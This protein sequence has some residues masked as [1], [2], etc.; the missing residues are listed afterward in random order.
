MAHAPLSPLVEPARAVASVVAVDATVAAGLSRGLREQLRA[1]RELTKPR[2]T[3]LVTIT[4]GVGF[5]MGAIGRPEWFTLDLVMSAVG[6]LVGT[7]SSASGANA[8][9]QWMERDRDSLMPRTCAR[10]LPRQSLT[11]RVALSAGIALCVFGVATLLLFAGLAAALVSLSTIILYLLVY[12]PLKPVTTVSTIVGA[13]PGAL[14]PLIGWCAAAGVGVTPWYAPLQHAGGWSL[15]LLMFVWQIPHFLAIA[16]M[17]RE[18]YAKGGY[19]MLSL[20]DASGERTSS[21][22][23]LWS[24][25]LIPATLSPSLAIHDRLSLAY[26]IAATLT[27]LMYLWLGWKFYADR[28]RGNARRVFFASI[29]HLPLLLLVMVADALVTAL[30]LR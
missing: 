8:L 9:N 30:R 21:M 24:V 6:C 25:A 7:A 22:I 5:V 19:R 11:P 13:V 4:S 10:P 2:I 15:F 26:P 12:T 18:D 27:G 17:Y 16:W 29:M 23:L 14:P 3:R 20:L 1:I 28:S